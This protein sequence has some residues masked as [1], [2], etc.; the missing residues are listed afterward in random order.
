M[1]KLVFTEKYQKELTEHKDKVIRN[2]ERPNKM[3]PE[4]K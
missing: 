1:R 2:S 3:T 4:E